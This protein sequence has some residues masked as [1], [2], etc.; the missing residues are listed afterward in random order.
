[1]NVNGIMKIANNLSRMQNAGGISPAQGT[2]F[3]KMFMG[4]LDT[5]NNEM[6][7]SLNNLVEGINPN[8]GNATSISNTVN[9]NIRNNG[10]GLPNFD[11]L[12]GEFIESVNKQ[13]FDSTTI[14]TKFVNGEDVE[15]HEVMIA[16]EKAKTSL[17]LLVEIRNKTIDMYR[18]LTR[19]QG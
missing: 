16:G 17:D 14:A 9:N 18:E 4:A 19:L 2:D 8:S 12:V 10:M 3:D 15:L 11:N 7:N 5:K 13:Q 6:N 1:M